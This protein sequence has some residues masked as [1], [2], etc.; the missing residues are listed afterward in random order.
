M[1][2][3][4]IDQQITFLHTRDLAKTADFYENVLG[5]PLAADQGKCRIYRVSRDGYVG[6]CEKES[7]PDR[8]ESVIITLVTADVDGWRRILGGRGAVFETEPK[9]NPAY[10]IYHC[11][12]RDPNG[13][14][15]EIQRFL[16]KDWDRTGFPAPH[17]GC[18]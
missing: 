17:P 9:E 13:Y 18:G 8:P 12:L 15:I 3:P 7:V 2:G 10:G 5:L 4:Q 14:R 16:D 11:F 6:F 1:E